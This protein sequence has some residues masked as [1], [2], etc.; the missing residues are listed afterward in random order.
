MPKD[1]RHTKYLEWVVSSYIGGGVYYKQIS[2]LLYP[3]LDDYL[4]LLK[5]KA[6]QKGDPKNP[7]TD[8]TNILNFCGY[9]G[10]TTKGKHRLGLA[11]MQ[12]KYND[13]LQEIALAAEKAVAGRVAPFYESDTATVYRPETA[14]QAKYYAQG[15]KWC[16]S[17]AKMFE[18]YS[19]QGPLYVIIP[20]KA[21]YRGEKYQIN[22]ASN[23]YMDETDTRIHP[24]NLLTKYPDIGHIIADVDKLL[25]K[26]GDFALYADRADG[27]REQEHEEWDQEEG[28]IPTDMLYI[29][30]NGVR[31]N[32]DHTTKLIDA[33]YDTAR[34]LLTLLVSKL[35]L[36]K[37]HEPVLMSLKYLLINYGLYLY[38]NVI[39]KGSIKLDDM[40]LSVP[41]QPNP[42]FQPYTKCDMM[43]L[44]YGKAA[45]KRVYILNNYSRSAVRWTTPEHEHIKQDMS[46]HEVLSQLRQYPMLER[47]SILITYE[48][49]H[50][51]QTK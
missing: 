43:R 5:V 18:H 8:E 14:V 33:S 40:K 41:M 46:P 19:K 51:R 22:T 9:L 16:T 37:S 11:E 1:P 23:S 50:E 48:Q 20:K 28:Y 38:G 47:K 12:N 26:D 32:I 24:R 3:A 42:I 49:L 10:C 15:T 13:I 39:T 4:T 35:H 6:L 17:D 31:Y 34:E 29:I 27:I 21:A 36:I 25:L 7:W 2:D 30:Y 44:S 45:S